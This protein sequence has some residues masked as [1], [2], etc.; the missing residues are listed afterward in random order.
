MFFRRSALGRGLASEVWFPLLVSMVR[1]NGDTGRSS[2]ENDD[3]VSL[4]HAR[5]DSHT[6]LDQSNIQ[7]SYY[8]AAPESNSAYNNLQSTPSGAPYTPSATSPFQSGWTFSRPQRQTPLD[9]RAA[10][11]IAMDHNRHTDNSPSQS[12]E[13]NNRHRSNSNLA[14]SMM[15][16]VVASGNDAL[17]ILFEAATAHDQENHRN[18]TTPESTTGNTSLRPI[19]RTTPRN[20]DSPAV[21]EPMPTVRRPVGLSDAAGETLDIWKACRFVKQGWFTAREAVTFMDM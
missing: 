21:F 17:N 9:S 12:Y 13:S 18:D 3:G 14:S 11:P 7:H 19:K 20:Y 4:Q 2:E 15:R 10:E 6:P 8:G 1:T 5:A 16:T